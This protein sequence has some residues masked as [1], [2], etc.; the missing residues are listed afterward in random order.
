MLTMA[1]A[2]V[3]SCRPWDQLLPDTSSSSSSSFLSIKNLSGYLSLKVPNVKFDFD[4][5]VSHCLL[6][7]HTS[8]LNSTLGTHFHAMIRTHHF[9]YDI[10]F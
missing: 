4:V 2:G 1:A 3:K 9:D 8:K 6:S 10:R 7:T 5:S